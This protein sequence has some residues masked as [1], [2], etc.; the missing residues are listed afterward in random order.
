MYEAKRAGGD[1]VRTTSPITVEASSV[2]A[3]RGA[4]AGA[5]A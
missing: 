1:L 4:R 5:P 2:L 3:E